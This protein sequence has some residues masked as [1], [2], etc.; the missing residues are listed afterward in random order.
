MGMAMIY[1]LVTAA[2]EWLSTRQPAAAAGAGDEEAEAKRKRDEEEAKRAAARAHG[3]PVTLE[4]FMAWKRTF[5]AEKAA[6]KAQQLEN[7]K[8]A[9]DLKLQRLTGRQWFQ[10]E[11]AAG[12][13]ESSDEDAV[14][15]ETE[16]DEEELS[17]D[18][19]RQPENEY[20]D[21]EDEDFDYTDDSDDDEAM[22]DEYLAS[23]QK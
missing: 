17:S 4:A 20:A 15:S 1:N 3:T 21:D 10:K 14:S 11:E 22:L 5:E 2:Q 7:S 8:T 6:E 16:I 19:R 18:E 13:V 23:K 12:A 9:E